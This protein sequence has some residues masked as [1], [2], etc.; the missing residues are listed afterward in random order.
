[1]YDDILIPTDGSDAAEAAV[2]E[3][4]DLA[5]FCDA[6]VHAV[7]VVDTTDYAGVPEAQLSP[8]HDRL[9]DAGAD[10]VGAVERRATDAGLDCR[11]EVRYGVPSD[12]IV[13]YADDHGVDLV[14]M[15]T[16]GNTGL[17]RVLLGSVAE[18]VIRSAN[19]PVMVER[20][21]G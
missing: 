21:D 10:A 14:V 3:G 2:A 11:S 6:T 16:R 13:E 19:Q 7:Y 9:E 1:M 4:V 12:Q 5:S 17:D 15:G 20:Y 18:N 8:V